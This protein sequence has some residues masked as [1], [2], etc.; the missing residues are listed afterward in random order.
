MHD[1]AVALDHELLAH[2]HRTGLGNAADIV[3]AEIDQHHVFG[4]LLRIGQQF[5]FQRQ[6]L[7][8][9]GPA[10]TSA[11]DRPD[12]DHAIAQP[13]QDFRRRANHLGAADI[14]VVHVGRGLSA[15]SARYIDRP[16]PERYAQALRGH[17]LE[18]VTGTHVFL[19]LAHHLVVLLAGERGT[20]ILL[21]DRV[22]DL[23]LRG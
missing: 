13:R 6:V 3:A 2:L 1:M 23:R 10:R 21:V 18:D 19:R 22:G 7:F 14:D 17:D 16:R 9:S 20:E 15:L 11:G 8:G 12:R 5:R 4:A